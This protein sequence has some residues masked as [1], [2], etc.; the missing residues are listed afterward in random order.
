MLLRGLIKSK[1]QLESNLKTQIRACTP[2]SPSKHA[3]GHGSKG[4]SDS[5]VTM[6]DKSE[7]GSE[8]QFIITISSRPI[9]VE[10][11]TGAEGAEDVRNRNAKRKWWT[12]MQ[13]CVCS[14]ASS[15]FFPRM[16]RMDVQKKKKCKD[17]RW[18]A[19]SFFINHS[20]ADLTIR[21]FLW[22]RSLVYIGFRYNIQKLR[23]LIY[24][25]RI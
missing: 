12:P 2:T 1:G 8:I 15:D 6:D 9:I 25:Q 23:K 7:K 24:L 18:A 19:R 10:K 14:N 13:N 21:G 20:T 17:L 3:C 11:R 5:F 22:D 4:G 16:D